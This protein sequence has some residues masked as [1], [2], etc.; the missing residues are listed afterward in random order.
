MIW[1]SGRYFGRFIQYRRFFLYGK[2]GEKMDEDLCLKIP[3]AVVKFLLNNID[4]I[5]IEKHARKKRSKKKSDEFYLLEC[6]T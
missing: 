1:A 6:S 2:T 5:L 3:R 4:T